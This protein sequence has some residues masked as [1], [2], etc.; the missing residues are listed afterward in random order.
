MTDYSLGEFEQMLLLSILQ[1]GEDAYG[2]TISPFLEQSVGRSVSRGALYAT[3]GRLEQKGLVRWQLEPGTEDRGGHRRR[4]FE[5]TRAG[6]TALRT[7]R[8]AL[9]EL[10]SGL[11]QV[12]GG[13]RR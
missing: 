9:T 10:W 4:R 13:E 11:D 3:L 7:Y 1:L 2:P 8:K 6:V 12:L 5:V